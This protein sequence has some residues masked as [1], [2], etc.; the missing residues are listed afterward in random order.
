MHL[1]DCKKKIKLNYSHATVEWKG[2]QRACVCLFNSSFINIYF[3]ER[4][5]PGG[6]CKHF[7]SAERLK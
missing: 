1:P 4:N 7:F 3:S 5:T 6:G 2:I